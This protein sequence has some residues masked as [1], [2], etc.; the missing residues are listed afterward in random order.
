MDA[1]VNKLLHPPTTALRAQAQTAEGPAL[2][3]VVRAL[4]QLPPEEPGGGGGQGNGDGGNGGA[5]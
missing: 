1:T 4:F 2:A 5:S 3:T